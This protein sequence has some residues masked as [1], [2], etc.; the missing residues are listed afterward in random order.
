MPNITL[1]E[2]D[3]HGRIVRSRIPVSV[4]TLF[5]PEGCAEVAR[6]ES[7]GKAEST[8]YGYFG[9][10]Y[11]DHPV[12][13]VLQD[14]LRHSF[15]AN[16]DQTHRRFASDL[17][18]QWTGRLLNGESPEDLIG[19]LSDLIENARHVLRGV[20]ENIG[21]TRRDP[22][23]ADD[24]WFRY[25]ESRLPFA[26][27]G[28]VLKGNHAVARVTWR[29]LLDGGADEEIES[30]ESWYGI[31]RRKPTEE[32]IRKAS[33]ATGWTPTLVER[34]YLDNLAGFFGGR[35]DQGNIVMTH[36]HDMNALDANWQD[37][38]ES[39]EEYTSPR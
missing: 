13:L 39:R 38:C 5:D 3:P 27:S 34:L 2:K 10:E 33:E 23:S 7:A 6:R 28:S 4:G 1:I 19:E 20:R 16:A 36:E 12:M 22:R 26:E 25:L 17:S 35:N 29:I 24:D 31:V 30:H 21:L 8:G 9:W 37:L 14:S 15:G 18:S 32:E 11:H